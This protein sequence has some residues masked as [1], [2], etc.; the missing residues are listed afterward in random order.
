MRQV[1]ILI[2][3]S[4]VCL[5]AGILTAAVL[6]SPNIAAENPRLPLVGLKL[7]NLQGEPVGWESL[8]RGEPLLVNFWATWCPPCVH[9]IPLLDEIA[10]RAGG[11]RVVGVSNEEAETIN[12]FALKTPISYDLL[13]TASDIF[14]FFH[15]N[16]NPSG[17]LPYTVLVNQSGDIVAKKNGYF[18]SVVEIEEFLSSYV[19]D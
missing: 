8:L 7:K 1:V 10:T 13:T 2:T 4:V 6:R 15:G 18:T 11:I 12:A 19:E 14:D 17:G 5:V 9:E 3:I 16:G